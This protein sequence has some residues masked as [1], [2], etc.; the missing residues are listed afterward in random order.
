[1]SGGAPLLERLF[2]PGQLQTAFQPVFEVADGRRTPHFLE[3]LTRGPAGTNLARAGVLF[4]YVRRKGK[5]CAFDRV[6]VASVLEAAASLP[7]EPR[8][9]LNVHASTLER[10][11]GFPELLLR[12]AEEAGI[13]PRRLVLEIV[14]HAPAWGGPRALKAIESLRRAGLAL[15]LDDIGLGQSNYRLILECHPDYFKIDAYLVQGCQHDPRRQAILD[16][17]VR[18]ADRFGSRVVAEGVESNAELLALRLLGV[19][20]LQGYLL[21]RP[22]SAEEFKAA[23]LGGRG[24]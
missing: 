6:C 8:L 20:L 21:A 17:L 24:A 3:C 11:A 10:D 18:L 23:A 1:M 2:Q 4:E 22:A 13:S 15:A 14:E 7:G 16:S 19:D 9:S 5:E 12:L